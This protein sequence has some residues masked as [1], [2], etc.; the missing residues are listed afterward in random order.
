MKCRAEVTCDFVEG[1][2]HELESPG[3]FRRSDTLP[4]SHSEG[5]VP[6]LDTFLEVD[7]G[8]ARAR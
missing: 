5:A 3:T 2:L 7:R 8:R 6:I 1:P 4:H